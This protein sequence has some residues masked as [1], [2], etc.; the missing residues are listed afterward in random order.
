[1]STTRQN[2][3][4]LVLAASATLSGTNI[5][6]GRQL[7]I[8]VSFSGPDDSTKCTLMLHE[9]SKQGNAQQRS[10]VTSQ[11][12]AID[13]CQVVSLHAFWCTNTF[14]SYLAISA[15]MGDSWEDSPPPPP[16]KPATLLQRG[17]PKTGGLNPN[18]SSFSF[19][20]GASS[21]VPG[22]H[23]QPQAPPP[24]FSMPTYPPPAGGSVISTPPPTPSRDVPGQTSSSTSPADPAA[25]RQS[26]S[27]EATTSSPA[28]PIETPEGLD[29]GPASGK[30]S[31][32]LSSGKSIPLQRSCI[33]RKACMSFEMLRMFSCQ[34]WYSALDSHQDQGCGGAPA[35]IHSKSEDKQTTSVG[36]QS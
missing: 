2:G 20:P 26:S 21:F 14:A 27:A 18:A 25:P 36:K 13:Q 35:Y 34:Q 16:P 33:C 9:T 10:A 12:S 4:P 7:R 28:K 17:Q 29:N 31:R 8:T 19:S 15:F 11:L 22:G 30:N 3:L 1:M 24:G 6:V 32:L 5:S 23:A